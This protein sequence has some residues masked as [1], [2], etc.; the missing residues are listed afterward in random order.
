MSSQLRAA[1]VTVAG[2]V[3]SLLFGAL[4]WMAYAAARPSP[5]MVE[6][7]LVLTVMVGV[8]TA[9]AILTRR[10]PA[11]GQDG[12]AFGVVAT[13]SL[14]ALVTA[15]LVPGMGYLFGWPALVGALWLTAKP[16]KR[17]TVVAWFTA[18]A[19]AAFVVMTPAIDTFFQL[20]QPRPGN[21]DSQLIPFAGLSTALAYLV[22]ALVA[23]AWPS[24]REPQPA[25]PR[26]ES[27]E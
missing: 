9:S 27:A 2:V 26:I 22:A 15:L 24:G 14:L 17:L 3:A 11:P 18:V 16:S 4:A 21:T 20:A 13:W 12:G 8:V 10:K 19:A 6:G 5:G 25:S 23:A 7:F 1:G